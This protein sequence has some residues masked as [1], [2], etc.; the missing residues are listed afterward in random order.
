MNFDFDI[1]MVLA[2]FTLGAVLLWGILSW[3]RAKQAKDHH[4]DAAVADRQR[5]EDAEA[6]PGTLDKVDESGRNWTKERGA[7]PPT[8]PRN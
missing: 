2:S 8:P 1:V 6:T 3:L 5:H 4:E 7:N